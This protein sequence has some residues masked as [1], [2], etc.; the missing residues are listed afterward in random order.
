MERVV[1]FEDKEMDVMG[2]FSEWQ[3]KHKNDDKLLPVRIRQ[4]HEAYGKTE[5]V[6]C[7]T[8]VHLIRYQMGA[9][10]LKCELA[11]QSSS[12]ATDWRAKWPACGK[13]EK[14]ESGAK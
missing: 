1:R 4:M 7:K 8:C 3:D 11:R 12:A 5:G 14:A 6:T 10:W 13:Y 9:S 2:L